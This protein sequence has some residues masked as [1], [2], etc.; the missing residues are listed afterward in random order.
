MHINEIT[1]KITGVKKSRDASDLFREEFVE[2]VYA[3]GD[4]IASDRVDV[5]SGCDALKE[6]F[7]L[8]GKTI[9]DNTPTCAECGCNL[10][11]KIFMDV[12]S[13]PKGLW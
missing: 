2:D 5:C 8:F 6:E 7:K 13:C 12:M 9:K 1:K 10:N 4:P 11:I 3:T